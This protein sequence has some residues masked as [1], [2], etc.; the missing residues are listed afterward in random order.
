MIR[1]TSDGTELSCEGQWVLANISDLHAM[2]KKMT[3]SMKGVQRINVAEIAKMDT[4]GALFL[5]DLVDKLRQEGAI[6]QILGLKNKFQPLFELVSRE[7]EQM[8]SKSILSP[9]SENGLAVVGRWAVEKYFQFLSYFAFLGELMIVIFQNTLKPSRIQWKSTFKVVDETGYRALPIIGLMSFLIGV[10][11]A[12]QL[13]TELETYGATIFVVDVSGVAILRE[14]G[15]LIT[16]V[17][18]AGRTSTAFAALIGTMKVNEEV[19]ALRTMGVVPLERLVIPRIF[20]LIFSLPLLTVWAD[21]FGVVG[22]MVMA[23]WM[24]DITYY[25]YL[26]RFQ[27][28]V[29]LKHLMLG[30]IKTPVF[31]MIIASVGCFQ[32]FKTGSSADSVGWQTTKAAVQSIFLIIVADAAFSILFSMMGL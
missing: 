20:G 8:H 1:V 23:N 15:P 12:Y 24:V 28:V 10:V 26:E 9:I 18:M 4:A 3:Q 31:A 13:T 27:Q 5:N 7:T 22:S 2:S 11:L 19:D 32:G 16:A 6:V 25:G 21:I 30:L 29:A 14:F 17:I